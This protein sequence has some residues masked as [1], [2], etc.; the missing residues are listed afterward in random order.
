MGVLKEKTVLYAD[1]MV[2]FLQDSDLSLFLALTRIDI[3]A[4]FSDLK[5]NWGKSQILPLKVPCPTMRPPA[6]CMLQRIDRV[7]NMVVDFIK[8]CLRL[9]PP[10]CHLSNTNP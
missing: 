4:R 10:K 7:K 8:C 3:F 2:L 9:Y 5:V 1:N 6:A